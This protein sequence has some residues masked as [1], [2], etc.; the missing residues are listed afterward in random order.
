MYTYHWIRKMRDSMT[1]LEKRSG[2]NPGI[3]FKERPEK[4]ILDTDT[5]G[6]EPSSPNPDYISDTDWNDICDFVTAK[7]RSCIP[8]KHYHLISNVEQTD[9]VGIQKALYGPVAKDSFLFIAELEAEIRQRPLVSNA[10]I[11][12]WIDH[13]LTMFKHLQ[14]LAKP[15]GK[16]EEVQP[17]IMREE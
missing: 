11:P 2:F 17:H 14:E 16:D 1:L 5:N 7:I 3:V 9:V 12:I 4:T 8:E 10:Q 13:Q 6:V 15:K